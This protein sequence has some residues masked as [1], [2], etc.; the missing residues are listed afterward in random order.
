MLNYRT[1][2]FVGIQHQNIFVDIFAKDFGEEPILS[3]NG[4]PAFFQYALGANIVL[5]NVSIQRA[6]LDFL[7]KFSQRL[8][9]DAVA[10]VSF[11]KPVTD[12]AFTQ[13]F[14]ANDIPGHLSIKENGLD[15]NSLIGQDLFP[16]RHKAVPGSRREASHL[17][18]FGVKLLFI[19]DGEVRFK[20]VAEVN[21]VWHKPRFNYIFAH[22]GA[23]MPLRWTTQ[24]T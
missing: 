18:R 6:C 2:L 19:K 3:G 12:L 21:L 11:S 9:G 8:G 24:S 15:L 16:V 1:R 7:Q 13:L 23:A 4:K 20:H 22:A 10:P 5:G 17:N 14:E